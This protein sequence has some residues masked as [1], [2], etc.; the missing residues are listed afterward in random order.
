M[1]Q[2]FV[3]LKIRNG[4]MAGTTVAL[5]RKDAKRGRLDRRFHGRRS[6]QATTLSAQLALQAEADR[7]VDGEAGCR[8]CRVPGMRP[9]RPLF[10]ARPN[11]A[12]V[13][14]NNDDTEAVRGAP[15]RRPQ[16]A[17][18]RRFRLMPESADWASSAIRHFSPFNR[19]ADAGN[20]RRRGDGPR[21]PDA[22]PMAHIRGQ[23][24][25]TQ[26]PPD[27]AGPLASQNAS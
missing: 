15:K 25:L 26:L 17:D 10:E 19:Y 11:V 20:P 7:S 8:D 13:A 18:R 2:S 27:P 21:E 12:G 24:P 9:T 22:R 6:M 16:E 3:E 14:R 1:V 5:P 23:S 4:M